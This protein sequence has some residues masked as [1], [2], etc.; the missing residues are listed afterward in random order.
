MKNIFKKIKSILSPKLDIKKVELDTFMGLLRVVH[1]KVKVKD[2]EKVYN[3]FS[4]PIYENNCQPIINELSQLRCYDKWNI[5]IGDFIAAYFLEV[6][7][8][9]NFLV[10]IKYSS[11]Y[12]VRDF[13]FFETNE[14]PKFSIRKTL[15]YKDSYYYYMVNNN[16]TSV[17]ISN[18]L[19]RKYKIRPLLE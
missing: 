13:Y 18:D 9:N 17:Y 15:V 10:V 19:L 3:V 5:V 4:S 2:I 6:I 16:Q 1:S 14:V 7:N 11:D 12:F 8:G